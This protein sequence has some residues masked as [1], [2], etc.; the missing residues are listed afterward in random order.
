MIIKMISNDND[1]MCK[2]N[3]KSEESKTTQIFQKVAF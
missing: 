3:V 2:T 1:I